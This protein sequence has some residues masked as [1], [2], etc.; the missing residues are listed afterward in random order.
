MRNTNTLVFYIGDAKSM[1][2]LNEVCA[3]LRRKG[4]CY[5]IETGVESHGRKAVILSWFKYQDL[6]RG[7]RRT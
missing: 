7:T 3:L 4:V 2:N 5:S 6:Y 1:A